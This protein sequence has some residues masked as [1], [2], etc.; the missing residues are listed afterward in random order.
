MRL[1]KVSSGIQ[2]E[3]TDEQRHAVDA[4]AERRTLAV[5]I[6]RGVERDRTEPGAARDGLE[7]PDVAVEGDLDLVQGLVTQAVRPP[8]LDVADAHLDRG[9]VLGRDDGLG[10]CPVA[11]DADGHGAEA[12][13]P[14]DLDV[15]L[16]PAV[17]ATCLV[18]DGRRE[19]ADIN[20]VGVVPQAQ[21]DPLPDSGG[22]EAGAPVPAEVAGHLAD[23][24]ERVLVDVR[25][26]A[27]QLGHGRGVLKSRREADLEEVGAGADVRAGGEH[28]A[29]VHVGGGADRAAV[30]ADLGDRVQAVADQ[31][32]VLAGQL[33][34][35]LGEVQR[36]EVAPRL[37]A[38]PVLLGLG[39]AVVRVIEDA[40]GD[41]VGV[42]AARVRSPARR[43]PDDP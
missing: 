37:A 18:L 29:P 15:D 27:H 6:G 2:F 23:E 4:Q 13:L 5:G 19:D 24:V 3:A 34:R 22:D 7:D 32:A 1:G 33:D 10:G 12:G 42:D 39:R 17:P 41:E 31:V 28:V 35:F 21:A 20:D 36:V 25:A 11:S 14:F 43:R 9:P 40:C 38:D 8:R 26:F 30:E 16:E